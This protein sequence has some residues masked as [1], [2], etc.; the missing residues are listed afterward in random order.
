M[1]CLDYDPYSANDVDLFEAHR[2]TPGDRNGG[3]V[4]L[5]IALVFCFPSFY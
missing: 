5:K 3:L 4:R 1:E 2:L